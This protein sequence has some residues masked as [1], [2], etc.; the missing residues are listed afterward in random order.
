MKSKENLVFLG[1]MGSGKSSIGSLIAKKLKLDFIDI[2]NEIE[3]ELGD[4][5]KKIFETK[6]ENYF[7]KFEEKITLKK[8]K[9][10]SVV[11]S[12]GGGAFTNKNIRQNVLKNHLSF[13]LNWKNEILLNR[14]KYSKKRPLAFNATDN[15]LIDLI[16]KR[17]NIYSK[18]LFE[19]KCDNLS[20]K[21]IVKKILKIYETN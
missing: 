6:G 17:S 3:N 20:K 8:L 19:I 9:L 16:K 21:D 13:W 11:I 15:E 12:L 5:I 18:A 4:S 10:N 14:I 2:D 7:R 1:M